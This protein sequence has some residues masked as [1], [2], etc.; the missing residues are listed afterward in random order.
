MLCFWQLLHIVLYCNTSIYCISG[1]NCVEQVNAHCCFVL[2]Y[3][4]FLKCTTN[5]SMSSKFFITTINHL[6]SLKLFYVT[7]V[8]ALSIFVLAFMSVFHVQDI[9]VLALYQVWNFSMWLEWMHCLFLYS[10]YV[11]SVPCTGYSSISTLNCHYIALYWY[12]LCFMLDFKFCSYGRYQE[13]S[14]HCS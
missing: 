8:K 5:C 13:S 2:A 12:Y 7:W 11:N 10:L 14:I 6:P 4:N 9:Q 3:P 1:L